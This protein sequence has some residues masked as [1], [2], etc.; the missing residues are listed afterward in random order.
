MINGY[1]KKYYVYS[2]FTNGLVN[3]ITTILMSF[4]VGEDAGVNGAILFAGNQKHPPGCFYF[5]LQR[6]AFRI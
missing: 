2:D 4:H 1:G 6:Y 3:T 5:I